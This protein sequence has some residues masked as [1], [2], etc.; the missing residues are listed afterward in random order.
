MIPPKQDEEPPAPPAAHQTGSVY[1]PMQDSETDAVNF[2][3]VDAPDEIASVAEEVAVDLPPSIRFIPV[4]RIVPNP[5]QPRTYFDHQGLEDLVASIK[6]HGILQPLV[7]SP[8]TEGRYELIAGERRFRAAIIAEFP[9]VP[10]IVRT[11][12]EQQKL[13]L[14]IIENVQRRDLNPIEEAR[15]YVRLREEFG[16]TQDEVG[17]RVGKSRPQVGNIIRLLELEPEIQDAL[18]NE[19][20][21]QSNARTLLSIADHV[22]RMQLFQ[23]MLEGNFTVRQA[24][25]H[26]PVENRR[27]RAIDPNVLDLESRLRSSFGLKVTIKRRADG[28][29]EVRIP[30]QND[31]DL[32][33]IVQT[34][35][36]PNVI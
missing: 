13:E 11:A 7:V 24:E 21:S 34:V 14:A 17:I 22:V 23:R 2:K 3:P 6:E 27:L 31:E 9:T 35:Q 36:P 1:E 26:I 29:G 28:Q 5:H 32:Q 15:A 20:I 16:L 4:E 25:Q 18:A 8:G 33:R 30:F 12:T 19:K 10:A